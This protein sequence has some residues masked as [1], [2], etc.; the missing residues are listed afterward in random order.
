MVNDMKENRIFRTIKKLTK[1]FV[2]D[3][4]YYTL[5]LAVFRF[6]ETMFQSLRLRKLSRYFQ[7]G[8][9]NYVLGYINERYGYVFDTARNK[10][11][12]SKTIEDVSRLP[13]WLCWLD[14][15]EQAP[16]LVQKCVH[17]IEANAE[18][19]PIYI[20]T[21]DNYKE[22]VSIPEYIVCKVENGMMGAAHF[23][24]I[25]RVCLLYQ[26]GGLWLDATIY[27]KNKIPEEYFRMKFFTCKSE[28]SDIRCISK[29][30]W[31][32]FCLGGEKGNIIFSV[33]RDFFFQ[34][35]KE[36][37]QAIDYLFFDDAIE[38]AREHIPEVN[39]LLA[40][41][42]CNNIDRDKLILRF[43]DPWKDGC[44]DDLFKGNTV[45][46]KLGYREKAYLNELTK[47][48]EPTVYA[49][50]VNDFKIGRNS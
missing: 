39:R 41:V 25:L 20:L 47:G 22:F 48:G 45:L 42:P 4:R 28:S 7:S 38:I 33:L 12:V 11:D 8:K 35:W 10:K 5:P 36:E 16:L 31:T 2:K 32:T 14:G 13:I 24:D 15:I 18:N 23:S 29:N 46:F 27:C 44:L 40:V 3:L 21:W 34:Y 50:F 9:D 17:S 6:G 1:D 30:Q 43:S 49:A 37:N 19:H 26:Y